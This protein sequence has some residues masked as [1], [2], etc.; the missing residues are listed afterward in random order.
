MDQSLIKETPSG[1][2]YMHKLPN[3][4]HQWSVRSYQ[5]NQLLPSTIHFLNKTEVLL[6]IKIETDRNYKLML[7]ILTRQDCQ[8]HDRQTKNNNV[9]L[10]FQLAREATY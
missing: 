2:L 8:N 10:D 4:F 7:H 1:I 5:F 3:R 9:K 6:F